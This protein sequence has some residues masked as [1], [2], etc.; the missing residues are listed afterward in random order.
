[1]PFGLNISCP[2]FGD[3]KLLNIALTMEEIFKYGEDN[4]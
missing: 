3:Q 4:E 1:M 2:A